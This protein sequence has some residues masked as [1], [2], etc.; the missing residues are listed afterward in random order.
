MRRHRLQ[1]D[2]RAVTCNMLALAYR[3]RDDIVPGA[4]VWLI[5]HLVDRDGN[6]LKPLRQDLLHSLRMAQPWRTADEL[7][8][9]V[10]EFLESWIPRTLPVHGNYMERGGMALVV[11]Y[12]L[13]VVSPQESAC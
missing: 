12:D 4:Q 11:G 3:A 9:F 1:P 8:L 6:P 2:W 13:E 10:M 7:R 5:T